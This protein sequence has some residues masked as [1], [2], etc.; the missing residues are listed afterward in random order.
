MR[1]ERIQQFL[2]HAIRISVKKAHPQQIFDL[3]QP[4]EQLRQPIAQAQIF[5]VRSRVLAD[6]RDFARAGRG[7]ILRFAHHRFKSPAAKFSA[8][9][10]E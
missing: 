7:Q 9:A 10:A 2:R 4:L 5:A 1:R 6:Q 8:Q 3:R